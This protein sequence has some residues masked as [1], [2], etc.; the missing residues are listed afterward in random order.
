[1]T[2][3]FLSETEKREIEAIREDLKKPSQVAAPWR[4]RHNRHK[5]SKWW[6]VFDRSGELVDQ[7]GGKIGYYD[8]LQRI[9]L[10]CHEIEFKRLKR[11]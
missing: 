7:K 3:D 1:M 2:P 8:D 4:C 11:Y 9:C 10:G 6:L 5:W